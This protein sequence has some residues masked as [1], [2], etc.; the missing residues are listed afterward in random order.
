MRNL[1][2]LMLL[3]ALCCFR[4][5][6]AATM[7]CED[8]RARSLS[9]IGRF[10]D[11]ADFGDAIDEIAMRNALEDDLIVAL[12]QDE[13]NSSLVD[14]SRLLVAASQLGLSRV[15]RVLLRSDVQIDWREH[16]EEVSMT[17]LFAA[18]WCERT[19]VVESL[20][21]AGAS[22]V[23]ES[24]LPFGGSVTVE[25]TYPL[26]AAVAGRDFD[27]GNPEIVCLIVGKLDARS[28]A[29]REM[30]DTVGL[31]AEGYLAVVS[32][33]TRRDALSKALNGRC[34]GSKQET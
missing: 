14:R 25:C 23:A 32:R 29:I 24:C 6:L 8:L 4:P 21:S 18:A 11:F 34:R 10:V 1:L 13:S 5:V 15:V 17:A 31:N 12:G 28:R 22:V 9:E 2:R 27:G 20:I 3:S 33:S 16:G 30:V 19:D 26:H 7:F